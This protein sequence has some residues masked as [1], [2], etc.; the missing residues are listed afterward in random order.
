MTLFEA[1]VQGVI[2]GSMIKLVDSHIVKRFSKLFK[3]HKIG[4]K[5]RHGMKKN[6]NT[7]INGFQK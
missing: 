6:L 3:K 7:T 1:V 2:T 5:I 4:Q